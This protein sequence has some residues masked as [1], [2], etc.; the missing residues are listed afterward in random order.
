M[1]N[2]FLRSFGVF[3]LVLGASYGAIKLLH[4][5]PEL[6]YLDVAIPLTYLGI[7]TLIFTFR[8]KR[9]QP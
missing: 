7:E 5:N 6:I 4:A 8:G 2:V 9:R 1:V 3:C